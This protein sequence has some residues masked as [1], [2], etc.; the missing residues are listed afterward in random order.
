[1]AGT[2]INAVT[3]KKEDYSD[4]LA[5]ADFRNTPFT[6]V[7]KKSKASTNP[8]FDW[9]V[10]NYSAPTTAGVV[11]GVDVT[12]F[13]DQFANRAKLFNYVQKVWR[14]P[15]V[16]GMTQDISDMPG[17]TNPIQAAVAKAL[18]EIKRDVEATC[19]SSNDGQVD[20]GAVSYKTAGL[21][22]W[23]STAG[24]TV[25]TIPAAYR[26]ASAQIITTAT[27]SL[28]ED[29]DLQGIL[30]AIFDAVGGMGMNYTLLCGSVLRRRVTA[31]T[32]TAVS[33]GATSANRVRAFNQSATSAVV[34]SST[35]TF[36]GDFGDLNVVSSSWIGLSGSTVD[37]DRGYVLDMDKIH[38]RYNERPTVNP[39]P[40]LGGGPR[41][42]VTCTFGLQVDN[43][44]GL[45]KFQP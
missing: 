6:S 33:G 42:S 19:L 38:L 1:M 5:I 13:A 9:T 21:G 40:D 32:R 28:D 2:L 8:R 24:G 25:V 17:A 36:K 35:T 23:I 4:L 29:T 16:S 34:E 39:L 27:A 26:P 11:D 22:T 10:D 30:T 3:T 44:K 20:D 7:V 31:M 18:V 37:T 14:N 41:R 12:D 15:K 45:G 43:P